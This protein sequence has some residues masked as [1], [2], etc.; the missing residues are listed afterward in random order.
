[1][2]NQNFHT[3]RASIISEKKGNE[4]L[5]FSTKNA[6]K[7]CSPSTFEKGVGKFDIITTFEPLERKHGI[8]TGSRTAWQYP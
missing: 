6:C 2:I 3:I 1:M 4:Y 5:I 7:K 8:V